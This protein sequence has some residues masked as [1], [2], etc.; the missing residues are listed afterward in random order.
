MVLPEQTELLGAHASRLFGLCVIVTHH[1][2]EM[3]VSTTHALVMK[4]G[5]AVA[6]G[7]VAD[8]V[9]S[10][11]LSDCFGMDLEVSRRPNGRFTAYA[12]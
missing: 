3:P 12:R 7:A 5:R 1:V 6:S 2:D 10:A 4:E 9:T 11:N 8:V